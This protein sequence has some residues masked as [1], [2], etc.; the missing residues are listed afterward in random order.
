MDA[1]IS[2]LHLSVHWK[3]LLIKILSNKKNLLISIYKMS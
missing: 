1:K 3:K 2:L